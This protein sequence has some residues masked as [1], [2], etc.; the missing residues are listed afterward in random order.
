[1]R[2]ST[3]TTAMSLESGELKKFR[4]QANNFNDWTST[5][6]ERAVMICVNRRGN[7]MMLSLFQK[8]GMKLPVM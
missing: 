7:L 6:I 2:D 3:V 1:M 4:V 5:L 8:T